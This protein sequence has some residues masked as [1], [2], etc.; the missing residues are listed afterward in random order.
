MNKKRM[1]VVA[2]LGAL[3]TAVVLSGCAVS[4]GQLH[5]PKG[6]FSALAPTQ[7]NE[8]VVVFFRQA[9]TDGRVPLVV[10]NDRVVGSL[11]SERYAQARVCA[12][13]IMVGTADRDQVVG[14]PQYQPL[15]VRAGEVAYLE[16]SESAAGQFAL[17]P[18]AEAQ[19]RERLDKLS[20]ASHIINRHVPDCAP[21]AAPV[22][23]A[24][25]P[26]LLKRVQLGADALFQFDKSGEADMLPQGRASLMALVDEIKQQGVSIERLRLTGHTDRLGSEAYNAVLSRQRAAT[27]GAFL[28]RAGLAMP[29]ETSGAGESEPVTR[30][31]IGT[32]ANPLLIACLQPDRRVTV[33]L[34]GVVSPTAEVSA[35]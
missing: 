17:T 27:V 8:A 28:K 2:Q 29:I 5:G 21:K 13:A 14:V 26:V 30:D 12:G 15:S 22:V 23:L 33:D 31:C 24:P 34:I 4:G 18:L 7:P 35:R 16:V 32:R 1:R 6:P 3:L 11:L 20:A 25:P 10:T 19:A 9:G